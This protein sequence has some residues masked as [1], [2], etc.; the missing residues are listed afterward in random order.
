MA[1]I[2]KPMLFTPG[3]SVGWFFIPVASLWKPYQAIKEIWQ[4]CSKHS[5]SG[6]SS[7]IGLWW[8]FWL[9]SSSLAKASMKLGMRA[10]EIDEII[11]ASVVGT[12]S[13]GVDIVEKILMLVLVGQIFRIQSNIRKQQEQVNIPNLS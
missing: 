5:A 2:Q 12:I 9:V 8:T 6:G 13:D 10:D 11:R 1:L 3:W 7:I 4:L